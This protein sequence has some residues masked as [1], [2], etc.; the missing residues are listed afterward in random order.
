MTTTNPDHERRRDS[1]NALTAD[2][3]KAALH[4]LSGY[5]PEGLDAAL[6]SNSVRLLAKPPADSVADLD[7][8]ADAV[9][10][11]V[12]RD[13]TPPPGLDVEGPVCSDCGVSAQICPQN[14]DGV[15][16]NRASCAARV[17]LATKA[18]G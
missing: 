8:V 14:S 1:I 11:A 9:M 10:K 3:A 5:T 15:C 2:Q 12:Y 4:Y 7:G 18:G 13:A 6:S 17:D 16:W